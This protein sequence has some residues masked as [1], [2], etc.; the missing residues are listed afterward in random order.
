MQSL[1]E[2]AVTVTRTRRV[3]VV[4]LV[5]G[6]SKQSLVETAVTVSRARRIHAVLGGICSDCNS[7]KA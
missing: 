2:S 4:E 3:H 6:V 1:V 5:Q 7:Y